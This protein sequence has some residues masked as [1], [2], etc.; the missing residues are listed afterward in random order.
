MPEIRQQLLKL[1][2]REAQAIVNRITDP[3]LWTPDF[4]G[5]FEFNALSL[6]DDA[7]D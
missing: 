5:D 4:S 6:T 1:P 3:D 7:E 2:P